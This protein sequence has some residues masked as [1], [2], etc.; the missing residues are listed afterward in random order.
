LL[1]HLFNEPTRAGQIDAFLCKGESAK[2][3]LFGLC[4][5][6]KTSQYLFETTFGIQFLTPF[7]QLNETLS[8]L[9]EKEFGAGLLRKVA[10]LNRLDVQLYNFAKELLRERF[11]NKKGDKGFE[12]EWSRFGRERTQN[13]NHHADNTPIDGSDAEEDEDDANFYSDQEE[14]EEEAQEI[15]IMRKVAR[16]KMKM[17]QENRKKTSHSNELAN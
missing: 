17:G 6:Q 9:A 2:D 7:I 15:K 11:E 12:H 5:Q 4:E 14:T 16:K 3:G 13:K 1:Q 10:R 8:T